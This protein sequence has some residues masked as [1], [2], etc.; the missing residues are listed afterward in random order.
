MPCDIV[1]GNL[2]RIGVPIKLG[3][4]YDA[5]TVKSRSRVEKTQKLLVWSH[6]LRVF[7]MKTGS[8]V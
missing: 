3:L 8:A 4:S 6:Q 5:L 7:Q 1:G 2:I